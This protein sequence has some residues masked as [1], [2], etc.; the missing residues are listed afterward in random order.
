MYTFMY[1]KAG[2]MKTLP[3]FQGFWTC[4]GQRL[5]TGTPSCKAMGFQANLLSQASTAG[6]LMVTEKWLTCQKG[7]SPPGI[8]LQ[9]RSSHSRSSAPT[10][11][12]NSNAHIPGL[13]ARVTDRNRS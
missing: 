8:C 3:Q 9:L 4:P 1:T 5:Y 12:V 13:T 6:P 11:R 7:A 2:R 10:H